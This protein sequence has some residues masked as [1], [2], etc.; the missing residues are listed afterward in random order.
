MGGE[1][2]WPSRFKTFREGGSFFPDSKNFR[3][4]IDDRLQRQLWIEMIGSQP[5]AIEER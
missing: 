2:S 3:L 1:N 4:A 5:V